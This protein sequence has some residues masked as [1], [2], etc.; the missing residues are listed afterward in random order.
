M[1]MHYPLVAASELSE[2]EAW[3]V[4]MATSPKTP[5]EALEFLD[6]LG[7]PDPKPRGV[8]ESVEA[9]VRRILQARARGEHIA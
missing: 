9:V 4:R 3:A 1:S 7:Y 2:R 8:T 5:P 6:F